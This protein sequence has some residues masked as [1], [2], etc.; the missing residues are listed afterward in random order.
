MKR[1]IFCFIVFLA[2]FCMNASL[3][4]AM[5]RAPEKPMHTADINKDGKADVSYY[6]DGK[7]VTRIEADTNYNGQPDVVVNVKEGK[8]ESAE[9]D[10]DHNGSL[11]K[12]FNDA[13]QFKQW[14]NES[15]PEFKQTIGRDN[16][17]LN[18]SA[19][20]FMGPPDFLKDR[21]QNRLP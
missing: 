13:T 14:V 1:M 20:G 3:C 5:G 10:T 11:D 6:G 18:P 7:N 21:P 4:F 19:Q 17:F 2:V 12:K 16:W 9:V 15:R 8:F